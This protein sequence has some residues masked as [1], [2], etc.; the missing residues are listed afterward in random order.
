MNIL[1]NIC[2][3][4]GDYYIYTCETNFDRISTPA[5]VSM[6]FSNKKNFLNPAESAASNRRQLPFQVSSVIHENSVKHFLLPGIC[7][8]FE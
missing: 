5:L 8:R 4:T 3:C 1:V 2:V 6:I 7:R